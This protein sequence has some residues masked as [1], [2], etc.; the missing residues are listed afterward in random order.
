MIGSPPMSS[1]AAENRSRDPTTPGASI[2]AG[3]RIVTSTA[4]LMITKVSGLARVVATVIVAPDRRIIGTVMT[5]PPT[6]RNEARPPIGTPHT[7]AMPRPPSLT[8]PASSTTAALRRKNPGR[9]SRSTAVAAIYAT[10]PHCSSASGANLPPK[11]PSAPPR[12]SSPSS[13]HRPLRWASVDRFVDTV[14]TTALTSMTSA[15]VAAATRAVSCPRSA[16]TKVMIGTV[17]KPPPN[18]KSTV[19]RPTRQPMRMSSRNSTRPFQRI[20][21]GPAIDSLSCSCETSPL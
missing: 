3:A 2:D 13:H 21:A 1:A 17:T 12:P 6:P 7:A 19:V 4:G 14:A 16:S 8:S 18:P 9:A 5:D 20:A 10:N 11:A 15:E